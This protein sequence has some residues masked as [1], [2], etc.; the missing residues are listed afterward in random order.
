MYIRQ[1]KYGG[2][3]DYPRWCHIWMRDR[4]FAK[5][6]CCTMKIT[7]RKYT[8]C[9]VLTHFHVFTQLNQNVRAWLT[10]VLGEEL[11]KSTLRTLRIT[12]PK[13]LKQIPSS[14]CNRSQCHGYHLQNTVGFTYIFQDFNNTCGSWLFG[15]SFVWQF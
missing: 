4:D 15:N 5:S 3:R 2:A 13:Y 12:Q 7:Y 14:I 8:V 1:R 11:A 10:G 9:K 6:T